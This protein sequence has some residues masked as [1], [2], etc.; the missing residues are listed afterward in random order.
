MSK[1]WNLTVHLKKD[2]VTN[3]NVNHIKNRFEPSRKDFHLPQPSTPH[4]TNPRPADRFSTPKKWTVR[5][6]PMVRNSS[7]ISKSHNT[8]NHYGQFLPKTE[9]R[10]G[11]TSESVSGDRTHS[12]SSQPP[13]NRSSLTHTQE[14]KKVP[15]KVKIEGFSSNSALELDEN[16]DLKL[17]KQHQ[18]EKQNSIY[19]DSDEDENTSKYRKSVSNLASRFGDLRG[20][21]RAKFANAADA[22]IKSKSSSSFAKIVEAVQLDAENPFKKSTTSLDETDEDLEKLTEGW[23]RPTK[24]LF[25]GA[26]LAKQSTNQAKSETPAD[27]PEVLTLQKMKTE[28]ERMRAPLQSYSSDVFQI[29]EEP[30]RLVKTP[31]HYGRFSGSNF[32][33]TQSLVDRNQQHFN[34]PSG[35]INVVKNKSTNRRNLTRNQSRVA[36]SEAEAREESNAAIMEMLKDL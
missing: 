16:G 10:T 36:Q 29:S 27:K 4:P 30:K 1:P 22:V 19:S 33:R 35:T 25:A 32:S 14:P 26:E 6:Y 23:E 24:S 3:D 8:V 20:S 12:V 13:V 11:S 7:S 5:E 28:V 34:R 15:Q 2:E 31:V 9:Y 17:Q 21:G 18:L